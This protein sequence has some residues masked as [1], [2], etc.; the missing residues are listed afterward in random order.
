MCAANVGSIISAL[1]SVSGL[2]AV[3]L[4]TLSFILTDCLWENKIFPLQ[5]EKNEG[6]QGC[7]S[8]SGTWSKKMTELGFVL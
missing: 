7:L 5:D 6:W 3:F 2:P 4:S 1:T 8:Y